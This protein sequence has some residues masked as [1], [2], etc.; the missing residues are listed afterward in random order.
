MELSREELNRAADKA[1]AKFKLLWSF[2]SENDRGKMLTG[3]EDTPESV[4][5]AVRESFLVDSNPEYELEVPMIGEPYV[6]LTV[7]YYPYGTPHNIKIVGEGLQ[8]KKRLFD[9]CAELYNNEDEGNGICFEYDTSTGQ[10]TEPAF[11]FIPYDS[12]KLTLVPHEKRLVDML[13][14]IGQED[15]IEKALKIYADA[16]NYWIPFYQGVSES[17]PDAPLRVV[18]LWN[19]ECK[20]LYLQNPEQLIKDFESIEIDNDQKMLKEIMEILKGD[21]KLE[22]QLDIYKD[23]RIGSGIGL[24]VFINTV[25]DEKKR[26]CAVEYYTQLAKKWGIADERCQYLLP[27]FRKRKLPYYDEQKG[28]VNKSITVGLFNLKYKWKKRQLMPLKAY[29]YLKSF[30]DD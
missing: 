10:F 20:N 24:G 25:Q 18:W 27:R 5:R 21:G 30:I 13:A 8:D 19:Q 2:F 26:D 17:R 4:C 11:G 15:R 29:V 28:I 14:M 9:Y 22:F 7:A 1:E 12:Q 3:S 23:G 16:P 6:D